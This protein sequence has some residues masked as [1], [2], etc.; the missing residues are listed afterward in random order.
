MKVL[1][2]SRYG[3]ATNCSGWARSDRQ[4]PAAGCTAAGHSSRNMPTII[5][6]A[7][8]RVGKGALAPCPPFY[9]PRQD[10][11]HAALCP[12]YAASSGYMPSTH[13]PRA[14]P[15]LPGA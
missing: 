3:A 2:R 8:T 9:F 4:R 12:P 5:D 11:G 14:W 6:C 10:G 1:T 7:I 13:L 15:R